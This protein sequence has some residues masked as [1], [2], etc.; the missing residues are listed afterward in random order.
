[1]PSGADFSRLH[2]LTCF[3]GAVTIMPAWVLKII[4]IEQAEKE[5]G[6]RFSGRTYP[7]GF[8]IVAATEQ[9]RAAACDRHEAEEDWWLEDTITLCE[10]IQTDGPTEIILGNYPTG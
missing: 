2:N 4:D 3:G 7:H 5:T 1:M 9:A 8:V 6:G 10:P